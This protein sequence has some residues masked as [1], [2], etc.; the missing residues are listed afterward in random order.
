M[1]TMISIVMCTYNGA[2]YVTEQLRSFQAQTRPPDEV[3]VLDDVSTDNTLALVRHFAAD[4]NFEV[5]V[6]QNEKNLGY[7]SN[8]ARALELATGD[9]IFFS[10]QDDVWLP[11]KIEEFLKSFAARPGVQLVSSDALL[12]GEDLEPLGSTLWSYLRMDA[13]VQAT[14]SSR[15]GFEYMMQRPNTFCGNSMAIAASFRN[16]ILPIPEGTPHD[17]W[18]GLLATAACSVSLL[19]TPLI[20]YRQHRTQ[21]S[22]S[23]APSLL[24]KMQKRWQGARM[25]SNPAF[26]RRWLMEHEVLRHRLREMDAIGHEA[27]LL[28]DDKILYLQAMLKLREASTFR[29]WKLLVQEVAG[30]RY[31]RFGHG[32]KSLIV[33]LLP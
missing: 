26:Y 18:I 31:F 8:F 14:L 19:P 28:I 12:V 3:L 22:G 10:D 7:A 25:F 21:V 11:T 6:L 24:N 32:W 2:R 13:G 29:R 17:T 16:H 1:P 4:C 5:K 9:I 20:K 23:K 33:D 27:R 15:G 30:G